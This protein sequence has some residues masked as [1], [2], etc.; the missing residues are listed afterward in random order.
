[1]CPFQGIPQSPVCCF[2]HPLAAGP[3]T[4]VIP[5]LGK[6]AVS[7]DYIFYVYIYMWPSYCHF[8]ILTTK[9]HMP[10]LTRLILLLIFYY[11]NAAYR[12]LQFKSHKSI[13]SQNQMER[14]WV[15]GNLLIWWEVMK[16][17]INNDL[18]YLLLAD[19]ANFVA[20]Y[21]YFVNIL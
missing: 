13:I 3:L 9:S 2:L 18:K 17:C 21:F 6:V 15:S 11:I 16:T 12:H 1:M 19:P 7:S 4:Q 20:P 5:L 14:V 8:K 10:S